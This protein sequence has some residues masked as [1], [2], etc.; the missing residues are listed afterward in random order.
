LRPALRPRL[1]RE[2][3]AL[4]HRPL[5]LDNSKLRSL[6]WAPRFATFGAGWSEVLRWYQAER[7]VPRYD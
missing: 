6:G 1:D 7:W 2:A 3:V 4:L 5:N